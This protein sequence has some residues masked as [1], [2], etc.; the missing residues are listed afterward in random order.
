MPTSTDPLTTRE[1]VFSPTL[2][3]ATWFGSGL[4]PVASGTFG[5]LAALPFVWLLMQLS[6]PLALLLCIALFFLGAATGRV[7]GL[8]MNEP[9]HGAI[10]V[11]EVVGVALAILLPYWLL[12]GWVSAYVFVIAGFAVFRAY[13]ILKPWPVSYFDSHWKN[14]WGVM[15][16]DVLAGFMAAAVVV[17]SV[18]LSQ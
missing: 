5:S 17:A 9:D 6:M 11:D 1:V 8:R 10:V 4:A 14:A 15:L 7:L 18:I 3:I 16:D 2:L 12:A 13:D